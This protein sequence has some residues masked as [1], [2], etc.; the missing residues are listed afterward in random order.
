MSRSLKRLTDHRRADST[1]KSP[2]ARRRK[3][4]K[5]EDAELLRDAGE[6]EG[7][8]DQGVDD[9]F[10]FFESPACTFVFVCCSHR[11]DLNRHALQM[12]RAVRCETIKFRASI[13]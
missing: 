9:A 4:E 13:G 2:D 3:S 1:L 10:T 11:S 8:E 12:S 5:E 6:R 7:S